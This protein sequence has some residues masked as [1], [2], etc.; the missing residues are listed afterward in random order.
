MTT[1]TDARLASFRQPPMR[2][3][4]ERHSTVN[5][6]H[7]TKTTHA[8]QRQ[9]RTHVRRMCYQC[10]QEGHYARDCPR[11]ITPKPTQTRMEKMRSL[12]KSMTPTERAQFKQ[13]INPQMT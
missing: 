10:R 11:T 12:L 6:P 1:G 2:S 4:R 8:L 13:E 7:L 5:E 9:Y 3:S